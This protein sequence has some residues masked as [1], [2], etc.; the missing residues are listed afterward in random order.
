[1]RLALVEQTPESDAL[2]H[3]EALGD[4]VEWVDD[5][6]RV[7]QAA[8]QSRAEA[9]RSEAVA[10]ALPRAQDPAARRLLSL[11]EAARYLGLGSRWAVRRLVVNGALPVVRIAGKWRLDVEDLDKLIFTLKVG[12]TNT[13]VRGSPRHDHARLMTT[14]PARLAPLAQRSPRVVTER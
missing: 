1:M 4:G 11:D 14:P 3:A 12:E 9:A 2:E 13:G 10:R 8:G 7:T 5:A 6:G